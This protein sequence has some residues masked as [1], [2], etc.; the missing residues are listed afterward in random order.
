MAGFERALAALKVGRSVARK[1]WNGKGMWL[2][3]VKGM[4]VEMVTEIPI[5]ADNTLFEADAHRRPNIERFAYP[6][7]IAM[8]TADNK[9]VPWLASMTDLMA[10]DWEIV[11]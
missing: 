1:G 4:P 5:L 11:K 10:D 9:L 7:H 6:D 3:I 2:S 8:K